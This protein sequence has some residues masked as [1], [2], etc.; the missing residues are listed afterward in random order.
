MSKTLKEQLREISITEL[1][2][3]KEWLNPVEYD[4]VLKDINGWYDA[5]EGYYLPEKLVQIN[6]AKMKQGKIN[7]GINKSK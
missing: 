3:N 6:R 4:L 7:K 5:N 1:R 2:R